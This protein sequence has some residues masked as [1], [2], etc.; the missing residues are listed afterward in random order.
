MGEEEGNRKTKNS[1]RQ[2]HREKRDQYGEMVS[3]ILFKS[4]SFCLLI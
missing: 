4:H 1:E 2:T 3:F